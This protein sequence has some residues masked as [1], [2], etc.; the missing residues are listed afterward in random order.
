V[1]RENARFAMLQSAEAIGLP[2]QVDSF[3]FVSGDNFSVAS[4]LVQGFDQPLNF[5]DESNRI[6]DLGVI[7]LN[8]PPSMGIPV[9]YYKVRAFILQSR[10]ELIDASGQ[11]VVA[12]PLEK[13]SVVTGSNK[14]MILSSGCDVLFIYNQPRQQSPN[15]TVEV[16]VRVD[17]S[18]KLIGR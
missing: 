4:A 12:L 11:P 17:W 18:P 3:K 9:G 14:P 15:I 8:V 16:A 7:Y 6:V 1:I 13:F 5:A 10:A 2:I